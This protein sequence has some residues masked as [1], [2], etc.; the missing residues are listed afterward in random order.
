MSLRIVLE[1][2]CRMKTRLRDSGFL[3]ACYG[4]KLQAWPFKTAGTEIVEAKSPLDVVQRW[5]A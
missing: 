1:W 5:L 4:N 3:D 2:E